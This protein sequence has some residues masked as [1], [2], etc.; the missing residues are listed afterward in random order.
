VNG[1][2]APVES[3]L[4]QAAHANAVRTQEARLLEQSRHEHGIQTPCIVRASGKH[5]ERAELDL[6]VQ[7]YGWRWNRWRAAGVGASNSC[8]RL[9][10]SCAASPRLVSTAACRSRMCQLNGRRRSLLVRL[11]ASICSRG[12]TSHQGFMTWRLAGT[13]L[14][15]AA[16]TLIARARR[17]RVN[18]TLPNGIPT[19]RSFPRCRR[20]WQRPP[21]AI[22]K[23]ASATH[24]AR[25]I[26]T[27]SRRAVLVGAGTRA[28]RPTSLKSRATLLESRAGG[29]RA[30]V[31]H[32][33]FRDWPRAWSSRVRRRSA[34]PLHLLPRPAAAAN[35]AGNRALGVGPDN[36][37]RL[38]GA[39][40]AW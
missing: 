31:L 13:A 9:W 17:A 7:S 5:A 37:R 35:R 18:P 24:R 3:H 23:R 4:D 19:Q 22:A 6:R 8:V 11:N 40:S 38:A 20:L 1:V 16:S 28:R 25:R 33:R 21:P 29:S 34:N 32:G 15:I 26:V 2:G 27:A 14:A 10:H 12:L 39:F 36:A 30:S